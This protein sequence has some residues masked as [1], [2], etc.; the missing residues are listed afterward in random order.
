MLTLLSLI[1]CDQVI[2]IRKGAFHE[3][4]KITNRLSS[5]SEGLDEMTHDELSH[6]GLLCFQKLKG[7]SCKVLTTTKI[8][9]QLFKASFP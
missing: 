6:M 5:S 8:R 2:V 7:L 4:T 3:K 1:K 9:A